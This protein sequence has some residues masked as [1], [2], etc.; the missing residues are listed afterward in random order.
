MSFALDFARFVVILACISSDLLTDITE[1]TI[2]QTP[3]SEEPEYVIAIPLSLPCR[4]GRGECVVLILSL[5]I[6]RIVCGIHAG[7]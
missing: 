1:I 5:G 7:V 2:P 4:R 6:Y 3:G